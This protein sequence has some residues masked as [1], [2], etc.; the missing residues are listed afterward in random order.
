MS[1]QSFIPRFWYTQIFK[2]YDKAYVFGG[3]SNRSY[4][5]TIRNAGDSVTVN[6]ILPGEVKT[7]TGTVAFDEVESASKTLLIDQQKYMA[8]KIDDIEIAQAQPKYATEVTRK[9]GESLADDV[10]QYLAGLHTEAGITADLGADGAA[11]SINSANIIEYM[12][13]V[14]QKMSE[15]NVPERGRVAVLP[16][17]IMGKLRLAKIAIEVE[18]VAGEGYRAGY[19]GRATELGFDI[20]TSNNIANTAGAEWKCMFFTAGETIALAS[21]ITNM[22]AMR[23]ET[24]FGEGI[25]FLNVYGGKVMRPDSLAVGTW[26]AVAEA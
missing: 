25:R 19:V 6:E 12:I 1:T 18:S 10:D 21:Q 7:Y 9:M 2:Q 15:N 23:L 24:T 4:E 5:G 8:Q 14:G 11:I 13:L 22:E 26:T 16:P 3:L 20:Y 17:A